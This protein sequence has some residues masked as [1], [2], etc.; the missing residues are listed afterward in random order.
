MKKKKLDHTNSERDKVEKVDKSPV[1]LK[2][3]VSYMELEKCLLKFASETFLYFLFQ[4]TL[5]YNPTTDKFVKQSNQATH[6]SLIVLHIPLDFIR[7]FGNN[8]FITRPTFLVT[9]LA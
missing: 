4:M 2:T 9:T 1:D 8:T 7:R 3:T 6:G 5:R